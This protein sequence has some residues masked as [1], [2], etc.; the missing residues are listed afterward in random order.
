MILFIKFSSPVYLCSTGCERYGS[1][2]P[3]PTATSGD[4]KGNEKHGEGETTV[5]Q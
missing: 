4:A 3:L 5:E 2:N 1:C